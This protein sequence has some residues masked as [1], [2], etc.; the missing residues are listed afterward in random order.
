MAAATLNDVIGRMKSEGQ[1]TRNNGT[2][3]LKSVKDVLKE[4]SS[5]MEGSFV[6]LIEGIENLTQAI[7]GNI[8]ANVELKLEQDRFND[9]MLKALEDLKGKGLGGSKE[10]EG[11]DLA[12]LGLLG[13]ALAGTIGGIIGVLQG[14]LK[15]V[16]AFGAIFSPESLSKWWKGLRLG[17]AM[18][19]ELFK[20]ALTERLGSLKATIFGGFEKIKA[21]F[22]ISEESTLGKIGAALKSKFTAL[23]EIFKP[24]V[25]TLDDIKSGVVTRI[26]NMFTTIKGYI[27]TFGSK[28][29][30][31][32]KVVGKIFAPIAVLVTAWDTLKATIEGWKEDG[33]LGALEGA[34]TGFFTSLVTIPLDLVKSAVSWVLEKLGFDKTSEVLDS[35]SFTDIFKKIVG[36]VFD[37]GKAAFNFVKGLLGFSEEGAGAG[38]RKKV[39]SV[40]TD[41]LGSV[42]KWIIDSFNSVVDSIKSFDIMQVLGD[43]SD[44]GANFIKSILRAVLPAADAMTIDVPKVETWFGDIGGGKVNLNPIPDDVYRWAGL[45]TA[46]DIEAGITPAPASSETIP[47]VQENQ[48]N[49]LDSAQVD[50]AGLMLDMGNAGGAATVVAP[51]DNSSTINQN[52]NTYHIKDRSMNPYSQDSDYYSQM[53]PSDYMNYMNR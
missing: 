3:S 50:N 26:G 10:E 5:M 48:A 14:Q 40:L 7:T 53:S 27:G 12:K 47:E 1:L 21:F 32:A 29:S 17:F 2:N 6:S 39:A 18:N 25:A 23:A 31:I 15:A 30:G 52:G 49:A 11:M 13:T 16:K 19:M 33:I 46:A 41:A 45:P 24:V 28:I 35:F 36:A 22:S 37:Y 9:K 44:M 43:L 38:I 4:T 51:T 34:I 20:Q 42:K 8:L